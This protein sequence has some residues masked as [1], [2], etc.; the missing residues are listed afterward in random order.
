MPTR[1]CFPCAQDILASEGLDRRHV[2]KTTAFISDSSD[3]D[4]VN[5]VYREFFGDHKPAR[6]I[7]PVA[8]L[9]FGCK[10]EVEAIAAIP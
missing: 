7:V 10:I 4:A 8:E 1:T 2:I 3:W 6:S 5:R 9:H